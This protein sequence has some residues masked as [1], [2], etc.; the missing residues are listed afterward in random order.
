[1]AVL[2][3]ILKPIAQIADLWPARYLSV[4]LYLTQGQVEACEALCDSFLQS[5]S[6]DSVPV[7]DKQWIAKIEAIKIISTECE[8]DP[9]Q[10]PRFDSEII[11]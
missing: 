10:I 8:M 2:K 4:M 5:S 7:V 3:M 11:L 6:S 9:A 1:M